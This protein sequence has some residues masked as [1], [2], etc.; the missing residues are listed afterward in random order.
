[1]DLQVCCLKERS[2]AVACMSINGVRQSSL[3][4]VPK[5]DYN[6][7]QQ[8]IK[9]AV[10]FLIKAGGRPLTTSKLICQSTEGSSHHSNLSLVHCTLI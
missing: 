4:H 3:S 2:I 1:M 6:N 9:Q 5:C 7:Q 10:Q 8:K